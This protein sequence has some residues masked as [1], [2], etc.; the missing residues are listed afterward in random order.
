MHDFT[1]EYAE[2]L[3]ESKQD[4]SPEPGK[5]AQSSG[6]LLLTEECAWVMRFL[7][8]RNEMPTGFVDDHFLK[9]AYTE[10]KK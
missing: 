1:C 3:S 5:F 9:Q 7:H 8:L 2:L 10:N 4:A 6:V